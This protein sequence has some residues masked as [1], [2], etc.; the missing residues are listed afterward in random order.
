MFMTYLG[1]GL[2]QLSFESFE[3]FSE[4]IQVIKIVNM[5]NH[6][7]LRTKLFKNCR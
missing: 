4:C 6:L 1:V 2:S 3:E 5:N 7:N